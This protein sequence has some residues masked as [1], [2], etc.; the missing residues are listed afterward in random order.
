MVKCMAQFPPVLNISRRKWWDY[1]I[2]TYFL[3]SD[4]LHWILSNIL[5]KLSLLCFYEIWVKGSSWPCAVFLLFPAVGFV[6]G[7]LPSSSLWYPA[8]C[9]KWIYSWCGLYFLVPHSS[10]SR[11]RSRSTFHQLEFAF[12]SEHMVREPR[13]PR[14]RQQPFFNVLLSAFCSLAK[15]V[16]VP[17]DRTQSKSAWA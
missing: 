8:S 13:Q 12:P 4:P 11:L 3:Y 10:N 7:Q 17:F 6:L 2:M 15:R 5:L 14:Q 16:L 1:M 9:L